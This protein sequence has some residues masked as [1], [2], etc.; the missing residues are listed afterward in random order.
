M[1]CNSD[2]WNKNHL[3]SFQVFQIYSW[4]LALTNVV[5]K[6]I[7]STKNTHTDTLTQWHRHTLNFQTDFI[8]KEINL[9]I[10]LV[11]SL[12]A[13]LV[14]KRVLC[15]FRCFLPWLCTMEFVFTV[16]RS[17]TG[18]SSVL[19]YFLNSFCLEED[20]SC[21]A[22]KRE[23]QRP[24]SP[25]IKAEGWLLNRFVKATLLFWDQGEQE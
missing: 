6:N 24:Q 1:I 21:V 23:F 11:K 15:I 22:V 9:S 14:N 3:Y 7:L 4:G 10:M 12:I 20:V 19:L 13:I 2:K 5:T 8:L 16:E 25:P 17:L 18:R